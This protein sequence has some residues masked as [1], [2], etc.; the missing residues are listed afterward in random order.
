MSDLYQRTYDSTEGMGTSL[1]FGPTM[2]VGRCST[3]TVVTCCC[4]CN[5][6]DGPGDQT[7]PQVN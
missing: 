5:S 7:V 2:T 4:C 3:S 6:E 1:A